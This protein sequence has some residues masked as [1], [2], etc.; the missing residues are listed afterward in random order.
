MSRE[1]LSRLVSRSQDEVDRVMALILGAQLL[2]SSTDG[3]L[4]DPEM[5]RQYELRAARQKAGAAGGKKRV[6]H[7]QLLKQKSKQSSSKTQ[8]EISINNFLS[9]AEK[10]QP[11]GDQCAQG[12]ELQVQGE[13]LLKQML[14]QNRKQN[15]AENLL[16]Q[17]LNQ[18]RAMLVAQLADAW[19]AAMSAARAP[20]PRQRCEKAFDEALD[21]GVPAALI[22]AEI[23]LGPKTTPT[24]NRREYLNQMLDR[25]AKQSGLAPNSLAAGPAPA[26]APADDPSQRKEKH[27]DASKR[28]AGF[29]A[30]IA[31]AQKRADA[32]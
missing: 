6:L 32:G 16:K 23:A 14:E 7:E 3:I 24:R 28:T 13:T 29:N 30:F 2:A 19:M 10:A 20:E 12:D 5:V 11:P 4:Y 31:E 9:S 21:E 1:H 27:G 15:E 22:L 26:D 8:E 17:P 18:S 25:L